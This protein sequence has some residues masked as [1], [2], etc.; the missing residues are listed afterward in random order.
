MQ[1]GMALTVEPGI[2]FI[3][4]LIQQSKEEPINVFFNYN[5]LQKY[6]DE[7]GGV[8]IE[9]DLAITKDGYINFTTAPRTV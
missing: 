8:R 9:D 2:Y 6:R 3:D 7:V 4:N 1:K 5:I